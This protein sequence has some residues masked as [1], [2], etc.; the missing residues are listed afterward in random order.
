MLKKQIIKA[1]VYYSLI[2]LLFV[3]LSIIF[4]F[5]SGFTLVQLCRIQNKEW[6]DGLPM[7]GVMLVGSVI[8]SIGVFI[9]AIYNL[10]KKK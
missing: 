5:L 10:R 8:S 3:A 6:K 7:V 1:N 4:S 9:L 2:A